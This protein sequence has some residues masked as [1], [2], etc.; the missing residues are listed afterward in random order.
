[1]RPSGY[2]YLTKRL[3]ELTENERVVVVLEGGY[4]L[5]N[6]G[7]ASE[8]VFRVLKGEKDPVVSLEEKV[9]YEEVKNRALPSF[10]QLQ[11]I[12]DVRKSWMMYMDRWKQHK[13]LESLL[14]KDSQ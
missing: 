7:Q 9:T 10:T 11:R 5:S 12:E 8:S 2:A 14:D 13:F 1:M 3:M 4:D 6:L